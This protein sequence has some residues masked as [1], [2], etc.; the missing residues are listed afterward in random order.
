[1]DVEDSGLPEWRREV[2]ED[3]ILHA[4]YPVSLP[5]NRRNPVKAWVVIG[6]LV[7][8]VAL[9]YGFYVLI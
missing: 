2:S 6:F 1:M 4:W 3:G 7:A 5:H 8:L 9:G